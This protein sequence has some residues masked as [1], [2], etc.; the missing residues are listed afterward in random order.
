[1]YSSDKHSE[2]NDKKHIQHTLA[3]IQPG[4]F[5][6]GPLDPRADKFF[7]HFLLWVQNCW[8]A[9]GGHKKWKKGQ[10]LPRGDHLGSPPK[11]QMSGRRIRF[12]NET[13]WEACTRAGMGW[14]V[15]VKSWED[16]R[17]RQDLEVWAWL[18]LVSLGAPGLIPSRC[19]VNVVNDC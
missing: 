10:A 14:G 2:Q 11:P 3:R 12:R 6:K 5:V 9:V 16:M 1:M 7:P 4:H 18:G 13:N 19:S 17:F 15:V 8:S